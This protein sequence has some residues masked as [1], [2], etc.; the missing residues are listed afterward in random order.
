MNTPKSVEE[1]SQRRKNG[2]LDYNCMSYIA[3][4]SNVTMIKIL[5][6]WALE[7]GIEIIKVPA[8]T[9]LFPEYISSSVLT[10]L[11]SNY[12]G[13]CTK[14]NQAAWLGLVEDLTDHIRS[15]IQIDYN[16]IITHVIGEGYNKTEEQLLITFKHLLTRGYEDGCEIDFQKHLDYSLRR[17]RHCH[18]FFRTQASERNYKFDWQKMA[19]NHQDIRKICKWASEDMQKIAVDCQK[20]AEKVARDHA[21]V[22]FYLKMA[23]HLN[24]TIDYAKLVALNPGLDDLVP[25]D[26]QRPKYPTSLVI[27]LKNL[28][29]DNGDV[30]NEDLLIDLYRYA[31]ETTDIKRVEYKGKKYYQRSN[32]WG[33]GPE[34][35][36][37]HDPDVI[38]EFYGWD[39]CCEAPAT[40]FP[41]DPNDVTY[42]L[43]Y[44]PRWIGWNDEQLINQDMVMLLQQ[45]DP[46][47]ITLTGYDELLLTNDS[48]INDDHRGSDHCQVNLEFYEEYEVKLP[49]TL[50]DF[51]NAC[52][53]IKSHKWG[54]WYEL[55]CG[56]SVVRSD[57]MIELNTN[58]D[59]GS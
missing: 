57:D 28:T 24:Q 21:L 46:N 54:R 49:A 51:M 33:K 42:H 36:P 1:A 59:H 52:Y 47:E 2:T 32:M 11:W 14:P 16:P 6:D 38:C 55:Y 56:G 34:E 3:I 30:F 43:V 48:G 22:E 58:F 9:K 37:A 53:R 20:Y 39:G 15:R 17:L 7:D 40:I 5:F 19:T 10:Y 41:E 35:R 8:W 31:M 29:T 23:K 4:Q 25:E 13:K 50:Y 44:N 45:I 12:S 18:E 27:D 26:Y